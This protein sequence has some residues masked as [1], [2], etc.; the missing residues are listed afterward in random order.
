[1]NV[2][3]NIKFTDLSTSGSRAVT[4]WAWN[5]GDGT[6]SNQPNPTKSYAA[7]GTFNVSLTVTTGV[8][9]DSETKNGFITVSAGPTANFSANPASGEAPLNVQFTDTS[10]SNGGTIT[11]RQWNFGD[12]GTSTS[13]N[14]SHTYN[15]E[16]TF[17]VTLTITATNGTDTETKTGLITVSAAPEGGCGGGKSL[18]GKGIA[19][20]DALVSAASMGL[21]LLVGLRRKR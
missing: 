5:F 8:G 14:P 4:Q 19:T 18:D 9:S 13:Q 17:T 12:G 15:D 2:G 6:T 20:G 21:L 3:A 10:N 1:V 16:G 7:A 11:S